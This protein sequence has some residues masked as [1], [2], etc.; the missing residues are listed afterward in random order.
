MSENVFLTRL[1]SPLSQNNAWK[2]FWDVLF[3]EKTRR[4]YPFP[5]RRQ[6]AFRKMFFE[7][8]LERNAAQI[9]E[10]TP[11]TRYC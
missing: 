10:F 11:P 7:G 2:I 3:S 5:A 9:F 1:K 4:P 6:H 8:A